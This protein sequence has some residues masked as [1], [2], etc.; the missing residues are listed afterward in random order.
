MIESSEIKDIADGVTT[1]IQTD[2]SITV[3]SILFIIIIC[4]VVGMFFYILLKYVLPVY[5]KVG[6]TLKE[7]SNNISEQNRQ[8]DSNTKSNETILK[9]V[10]DRQIRIENSI[11]KLIYI[12]E[13]DKKK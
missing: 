7:L 8:L 4:V 3:F 1:V 9:E 11:D 12:I 6:D 5:A 13:Q 2:I 10:S